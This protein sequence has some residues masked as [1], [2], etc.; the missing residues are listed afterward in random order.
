MTVV[1]GVD[2]WS[3]GWVG[4]ELRDG[5]FAEA[6]QE[7]TLDALLT[8]VD[9]DAIAIDIPLGL[10][11]RGWRQ[12]DVEA[13]KLLGRRSSRVFLTPPRAALAQVAHAAASSLC[14]ELNQQGF[15][16]Q[17]W[18]LKRKLLEANVI[19]DVGDLR[20]YEVHPEVSFAAMGLGPND[21]GKKTWA[22]QRQRLRLLKSVG[23]HL[24]DELG[25]A[26]V[27]PPDDVIDA[28]AA[29]WSAHRIATAAAQWL[30]DP[31]QLNERGQQVAIWY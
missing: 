28:T 2:G 25:T 31:P 13:K 15:S 14:R 24:P 30:P 8:A 26:G 5:R 23:I 18:G 17:A 20:L 7:A 19:N 21:T 1:V 22:G 6:R 10:V 9:A 11:E 27:V 12:A 4:V 3:R 16:I 29:A